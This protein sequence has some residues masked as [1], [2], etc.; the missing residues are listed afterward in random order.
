MTHNWIDEY[1]QKIQNGEIITGLWIKRLYEIITN[2][3]ATGEYLFKAEIADKAIK[4]I[5]TF[6]RHCEGRSDMLKLEL[7]QKAMLSVIFG[8]LDMG[9]APGATG[10]APLARRFREVLIIVGR[11]NGKTLL[12]A[13]IMCYMAFCDGEYGAK[14]YCI[15]P[16]LDQAN[17]LFNNFYQMLKKEPELMQRAHKRRVDIYI[18]STNTSIMPLAF[19][20]KKS[21]GFNPHLVVN[22]EIAS[23]TSEPGLKQYEVMKSA[24]GARR[25][26]LIISISTAGYVNEGIY[27]ELINRSTA[28]LRND[29]RER[30]LLPFLYMVDK[31][32]KWDDITELKKANP[33]MGVSVKEDFFAEEIAVAEQSYSKRVEFLTKYC[34]VKQNSSAAWLDYATVDKA[35]LP[36]LSLEDFRGCYAVAGIDLSQ[37]TDLTAASV[38]IERKGQLYCF[39]QFYMPANKLEILTSI[40]GVPYSAFVQKGNLILSGENYVDYRDVSNW[41]LSLRKDYE[42]YVMYIGYDKYSAQYLVQELQDYGFNTDDVRQGLNL[43]PVILEF[44]GIIKDGNFFIVDNN[45][46][47]AHFLNVALSHNL[48]TR[49]YKPVK[50]EQRA[51]IDGFVSVID[52]LTVRQKYWNELCDY[53]KNE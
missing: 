10:A 50:I 41:L 27:D 37:T 11:K 43:S 9:S 38:L 45:L 48:E 33:N 34:N 36:G 7:W 6:C 2:G 20:A 42:I 4:F 22:D 8:V 47:K 1:W 31:P 52:A 25:Q 26:P 44:E 46:L 17:I 15:A 14:L 40:D 51:R 16:K 21:D 23:W 49:K 29:S 5:E 35:S 39:T 28:F 19:S 32:D 18:A 13:A 12:A 53:L 30:R 24:L 3:I